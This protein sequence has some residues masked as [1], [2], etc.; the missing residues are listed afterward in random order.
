MEY[1]RITLKAARV[2]ANLSQKA[3]AK[4]LGINVSTLQNY[5]KGQTVPDWDVVKRIEKI[6]N[7]PTDFIVFT[8]NSALSGF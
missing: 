6:Y 8:R 5:E 3:A 2:N 7:F 1:P 4:A